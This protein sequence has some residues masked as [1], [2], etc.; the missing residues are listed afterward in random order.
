MSETIGT[1]RLLAQ[2]MEA[3][4]AAIRYARTPKRKAR[5]L[6]L[7]SGKHVWLNH[8]IRATTKIGASRAWYALTFP[9]YFNADTSGQLSQQV[10]DGSMKRKGYACIELASGAKGEWLL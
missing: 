2:K 9:Q 8:A 3:R 5:R 6:F 4:T 10:L 1:L 7:F